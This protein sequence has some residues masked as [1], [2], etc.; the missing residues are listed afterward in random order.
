[1]QELLKKIYKTALNLD[2]VEACV[3]CDLCR[4]PKLCHS[5]LDVL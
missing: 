2:A 5:L 1:M 3:S 4:M